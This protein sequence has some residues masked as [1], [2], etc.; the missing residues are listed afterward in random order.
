MELPQSERRVRLERLLGQAKPPL[1][2]TPVTRDRAQAAG[3][4][5]AASRAPAWT[6]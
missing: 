6:A 3:V 5:A 4:A 2:L 1:Y